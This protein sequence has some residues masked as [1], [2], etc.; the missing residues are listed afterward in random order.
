[1]FSGKKSQVTMFIILG[2]VILAVVFAVFYFLG[3]KITKQ[4]ETDI[5]FDEGSIDPVRNLVKDCVEKEVIKGAEL[6]GKQG[7][8]YDPVKYYTIGE[9]NL[10]YDCYFNSNGNNVNNLPT[11]FRISREIEEYL[12]TDESVSAVD[13]CIDDFNSFEGYKFDEGDREINIDI[14]NEVI[15]VDV[16][17]PIEIKKGNSVLS[18]EGVKFDVL[19]G[20][21]TAYYVAVDVI[22]KECNG[23][24]FDLDNYILEHNP[25]AYIERQRSENRLYYYITSIPQGDEDEFRFHFIVEK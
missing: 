24:E 2:I 18:M 25:L 21:G 11:L 10:S 7:G 13:E 22:N 19:S 8:Y 12:R 16:D 9:Y 5:I 20:L 23:E 15:I 1:M 17:Y 6:V 14:S 4:S 3:D